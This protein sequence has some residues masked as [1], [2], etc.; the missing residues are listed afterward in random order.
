MSNVID[1]LLLSATKTSSGVVIEMTMDDFRR[2]V[3]ALNYS[4]GAWVATDTVTYTA[5]KSD[6]QKATDSAPAEDAETDSEQ[7]QEQQSADVKQEPPARQEPAEQPAETV[8]RKRAE[9]Q[10]ITTKQAR[11]LF[12]VALKH[13]EYT[14]AE[15]Q[16]GADMLEYSCYN[17]NWQ[18]DI[19]GDGTMRTLNQIIEL[20]RTL[21]ENGFSR[22]AGDVFDPEAVA[23][24]GI[25]ARFRHTD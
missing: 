12:W 3:S 15:L 1:D 5:D 17:P 22:L 8:K 13:P 19:F 24:M 4:S 21:G 10:R 6:P 14:K 16:R 23:Q 7:P 11:A 18:F 9:N 20:G 2:L 25:S